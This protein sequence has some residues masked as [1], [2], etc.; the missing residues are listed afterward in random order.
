MGN[1][2]WKARSLGAQMEREPEYVD[3]VALIQRETFLIF[4][5]KQINDFL[6]SARYAYR[7]QANVCP[8]C[9]RYHMPH[10]IGI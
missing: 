4:T 7:A 10:C 5:K 3:V 8:T 9:Q 6:G 1:M 2:D